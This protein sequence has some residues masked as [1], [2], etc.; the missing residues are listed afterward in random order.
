MLNDTMRFR[1]LEKGYVVCS[2]LLASD[3]ILACLRKEADLLYDHSR[4]NVVTDLG[5]IIQP[6]DSD[7]FVDLNSASSYGAR[8]AGVSKYSLTIIDLIC[9]KLL[10]AASSLLPENQQILFLNEQ[11]I[12]KPPGYGDLTR[13]PWHRDDQYIPSA[14]RFPPFISCWVCLDATNL[15]NGALDLLP[16]Y[17]T[18]SESCTLEPSIEIYSDPQKYM[19]WHHNVSV[20]DLPPSVPIQCHIRNVCTNPGDVVFMSS[21]VLHRSGPNKSG[22][23]RRAYMAQFSSCPVTLFNNSLVSLSFPASFLSDSLQSQ[24]N[25]SPVAPIN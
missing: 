10:D 20:I 5:C 24:Q 7:E 22:R 19:E 4:K 13:F 23:H 17:L 12:I 8:R 6:I 21:T 14:A 2:D 18:T 9:G 25:H 3:E 1:Y 11:Y 15:N 16:Y